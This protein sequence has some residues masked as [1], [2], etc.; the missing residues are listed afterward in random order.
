MMKSKLNIPTLTFLSYRDFVAELSRREITELRL[1]SGTRDENRGAPGP[2][3]NYI[4]T[5]TAVSTGAGLQEVMACTFRVGGCWEIFS[6]R[7]PECSNNLAG[8]VEV[9]TED[10]QALGIAV[11]P[12]VYA[13]ETNW[14]YG[15]PSGLWHFRRDGEKH[16]LIPGGAPDEP[17][18]QVPHSMRPKV[19]VQ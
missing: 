11:L 8:A 14:G 19:V 12:G 16:I 5:L 15:H 13:H 6:D 10:L 1:E 9:L 7:H 18:A 3:R 2:W 4:V 17:C